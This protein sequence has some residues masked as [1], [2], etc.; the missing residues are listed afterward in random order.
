MSEID[1]TPTEVVF[2]P[3][4]DSGVTE[5]TSIAADELADDGADPWAEDAVMAEVD[6]TGDEVEVTD[7]LV[8]DEATGEIIEEVVIAESEEV[9]PLDEFRRQLEDAPGDW[10]LLHTYSGYEKRVRANI[11]NVIKTQDL[12]D[13]IFQIEVPEETVWE[14]KQGQRKKVD[15]R[16]F[17]GYVLVRMYLTDETWSAIRNTPAVTGF[18]GQSDRPVPLSLFEVE[19]MLAPEPTAVEATG[20]AAAADAGGLLA[21]ANK[22][23]EIDLSVGDSVTVID[24]PFATLHATI[25]EI[26]ID[27]GKITGL[28]EI[29]G[30]ETPVELNFSQIQKN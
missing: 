29:F 22:V 30:R 19:R 28:V 21:P 4:P 8:V 11:E 13:D 25:S 20:G 3:V 26:N 6:E 9:D 16:K 10:Y 15:R 17:P 7:V 14:I 23:T 24:G 1:E 2:E 12:E 5:P 18:V 27:A